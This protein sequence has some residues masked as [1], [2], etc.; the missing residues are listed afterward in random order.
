MIAVM[1]MRGVHHRCLCC[2]RRCCRSASSFPSSSFAFPSPFSS[3]FLVS[4]IVVSSVFVV[5]ISLLMFF[6]LSS[7]LPSSFLM[8]CCCLRHCR[9]YYL[10]SP[11]VVPVVRPLS[12]TFLSL[13]LLCW[14]CISPTDDDDKGVKM[15]CGERCLVP[16][17]VCCLLRA[18]ATI[19]RE[20]H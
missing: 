6:F 10:S 19:S 14:R 7:L 12:S 17:L 11:F 4:S 20:E 9:G 15:S 16:L 8:L 3:F 2:S 18:S 5:L 1:M 13:L